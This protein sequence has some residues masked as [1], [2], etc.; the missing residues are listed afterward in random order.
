MKKFWIGAIL[1]VSLIT[2]TGCTPSEEETTLSDALKFKQEY[3]AING[4]ENASGKVHRSL[5]IEE[6]NP[7]VYTTAEDIV[8]K[9]ENNETFYVYFGSKLC[10]WCRSVIEKFIEVANL[11]NVKTIYYV[12][13][14]DEEGK[15]ILRDQYTLKDGEPTKTQ[16]GTDAYYQLLEL[17]NPLLE[18]YTLTDED[19]KAQS[20]GEKRIYAPSFIY[21]DKGTPITLTEGI[22]TLQED[23]RGQLTDEILAD[24]QQQFEEF[25]KEAN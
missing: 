3:E 19:G 23:S 14:W 24:E 22:S 5:T 11:N 25:F 12:D 13:I 17:L 6:D 1:I 15:E 20:T 10:P 7:I 2:L 16:E 18:D 21:I 4:K 8:K 9:I